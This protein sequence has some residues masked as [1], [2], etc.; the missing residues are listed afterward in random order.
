MRIIS[1]RF[2]GRRFSPNMK[3][4]PTRPTTDKT[5]EALFNILD[6]TFYWDKLSALDL[7]AGT[8]SITYEL[9]SRGCSEVTAVERA[10]ACVNFIEEMLETLDVRSQVQLHRADVWSFIRQQ[11]QKQSFKLVYADPPYDMERLPELPQA[12]LEAG[13][14]MEE[15]WLV[16]EHDTQYDFE[17]QPHF[18][19]AR[20]Y[21]KTVLSIFEYSAKNKQ[22]EEG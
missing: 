19:E 2:R 1:G 10:G 21:G 13:L 9:L 12:I 18:L 5:R 20:H 15:G 16:L 22:V 4:W 7:F 11:Q 14:V 17:E 3:K 8:G 6:N